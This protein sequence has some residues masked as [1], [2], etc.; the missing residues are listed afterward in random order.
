MYAKYRDKEFEIL[1]IAT[2]NSKQ[3]WIKDLEKEKLPWL[4]VIDLQGN[5]S[6]SLNQFA[7]AKYPTT[8]LVDPNGKIIG[9]DLSVKALEA[10][11]DKL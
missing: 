11:L 6:V 8:V 4:Q 7:I 1:G 2:E 5:K 3:A 9:R 10:I